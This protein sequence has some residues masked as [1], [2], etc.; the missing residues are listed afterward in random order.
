MLALLLLA[1][2]ATAFVIIARRNWTYIAYLGWRFSREPKAILKK[3]KA[4]NFAELL[5]IKGIF[6]QESE[7]S[8]I[9]GTV[10]VDRPECRGGFLTEIVAV[11]VKAIPAEKTHTGHCGSYSL[12]RGFFYTMFFGADPKCGQPMHPNVPAW[13]IEWERVRLFAKLLFCL[14]FKKPLHGYMEISKD[15]NIL[16]GIFAFKLLKV[17]VVIVCDRETASYIETQGGST[18]IPVKIIFS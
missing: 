9:Y 15:G 7:L 6:L 12:P 5:N 11:G 3:Y 16:E 8:G 2:L 4:K 10:F 14:L 1:L 13:K 17:A 18:L